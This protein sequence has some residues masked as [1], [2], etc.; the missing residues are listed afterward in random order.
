MQFFLFIVVVILIIIGA[1]TIQN[2]DTAISVKFI[3]W[4][5]T[6]S[7]ASVLAVPFVAGIVA[8]IFMFVPPWIKKAGQA[9]S[10]KKRVQELESEL[11]KVSE[12]I[13]ADEAEKELESGQEND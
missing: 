7:I 6:G 3:K 11:V 2:P 13:E 4:T 5:F 8:S 12:Q 10:S 1:I 9:R